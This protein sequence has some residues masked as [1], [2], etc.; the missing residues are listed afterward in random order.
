MAATQQEQELKFEL[1][2]EVAS[3]E[4]LTAIS[5]S[6][7]HLD[8]FGK[9]FNIKT[10]DGKDAHTACIG[11]G[12]ERIALALFKKHGLDLKKWPLEVCEILEL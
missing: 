12:L 11:F 4:K 8:H 5:S 10:A 9:E 3:G 6:N 7:C 1:V 2:T